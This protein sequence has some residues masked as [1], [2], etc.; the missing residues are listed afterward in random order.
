MENKTHENLETQIKDVQYAKFLMDFHRDVEAF[1]REIA[2][3]H[4]KRYQALLEEQ[5]KNKK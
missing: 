1:H 3:M 2:D 5:I 4:E